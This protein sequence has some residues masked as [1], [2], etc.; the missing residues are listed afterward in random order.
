MRS[1]RCCVNVALIVI[2]L[3]ALELDPGYVDTAIRRWQALT[4]GSARHAVSGRSFD[5]LAREMEAGNAVSAA[6]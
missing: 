4:G 3:C 1:W 6:A 2:A 5:D